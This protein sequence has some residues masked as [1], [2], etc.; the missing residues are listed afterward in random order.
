[1]FF[2]SPQHRLADIFGKGL[3]G[4]SSSAMFVYKAASAPQEGF[5][6]AQCRRDFA[7]GW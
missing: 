5:W 2:V 7:A 6:I 3:R 1:L 4:A